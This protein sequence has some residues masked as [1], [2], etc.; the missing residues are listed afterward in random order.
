MSAADRVSAGRAILSAWSR[1]GR[2]VVAL[3][4]AG[5]TRHL[6]GAAAE[7]L[8]RAVRARAHR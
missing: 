1:G 8:C 2:L 4:E 7:A 5:A 6:Y 3:T